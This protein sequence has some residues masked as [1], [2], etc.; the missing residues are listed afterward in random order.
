VSGARIA[1]GSRAPMVAAVLLAAT[2]SASWAAIDVALVSPSVTEPAF[3]LVE[4]VAEVTSDAPVR[5][6]D[7]FVDGQ[8]AGRVERP[9]YRLELDV[10]QA[11]VEHTF[12][13]VAS[14]LLGGTAEASMHTPRIDVNES[15]D[16]ELQQLF[17]SVTDRAG[18]PVTGLT[19]ADFQV[20]NDRGNRETIVTFGGGDL[21]ISSVLLLDASESM[22]GEPLAAALTG[23]E[24][25]VDRTRPE[26][27]TMV[28]FFSD[29]LLGATMFSRDDESLRLALGE[30]QATGGT[31]VN[32]HLYYALNRL[33]PRLGRRVVVLLSDGLDVSSFL[34]MEQVLWRAR[35]SQAMLYW[36]RLGTTGSDRTPP[37]YSTIWRDSP[38]N[39][40]Q[41]EALTQAVT[42]SGGRILDI[43][44]VA[45]I[46]DAFG[47]VIDE[48]RQQ[49]V[50]GFHPRDARNDGSWRP[51]RVRVRGSGL[52]VRTRA[53]YV[54]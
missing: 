31:A 19:A 46:D 9:P 26:D 1:R 51:L 2:S 11:N 15:F 28:A 13:A 40:R 34:D 8:R 36:L 35:R 47:R 23:V 33:Q 42:E 48:L 54:D 14:D 50:L 16:V 6:V 5:Y 25:F 7:F 17:A 30:V 49:Y 4:L 41:Y 3:G 43:A 29:R 32:D 53:G 44:D 12:R 38:A 45:D 21:P 10:G 22:R 18:G 20:V 52:A 39:R 27:E 24:R 37:L